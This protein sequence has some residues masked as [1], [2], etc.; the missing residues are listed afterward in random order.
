VGDV[1]PSQPT[2]TACTSTPRK[3]A[4]AS[5]GTSGN[6][7]GAP[8]GGST[9]CERQGGAERE[10][11]AGAGELEPWLSKWGWGPGVGFATGPGASSEATPGPQPQPGGHQSSF[12]FMGKGPSPPRS[13]FGVIFVGAVLACCVSPAPRISCPPSAPVLPLPFVYRTGERLQAK[14][15]LFLDSAA[16]AELC[17][18]H[19]CCPV[20]KGQT[21]PLFQHSEV[22]SPDLE[23]VLAVSRALC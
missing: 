9:S 3:L 8:A 6:A 20:A 22:C 7:Q 14:K 5:H 13:P 10:F 17:D 12:S 2:P 15:V 16:Q 1:P 18:G 21:V 23:R 19:S 11:M 4:W